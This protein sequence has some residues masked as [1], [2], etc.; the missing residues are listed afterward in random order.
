M[1]KKCFACEEVV[2]NVEE[3][4]CSIC[5][6]TNKEILSVT[7]NL[8]KFKKEFDALFFTEI[9]DDWYVSKK[10]LDFFKKRWGL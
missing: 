3:G 2:I 6:E 5:L 7:G 4:V 9:F 8:E 10:E 1:S